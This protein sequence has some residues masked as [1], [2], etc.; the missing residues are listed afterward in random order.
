[1]ESTAGA[2][3]GAAGAVSPARS[4]GVADAGSNG[5]DSRTPARNK[6]GRR[7]RARPTTAPR[8]SRGPSAN[9]LMIGPSH[10]HPSD[11]TIAEIRPL[12]RVSARRFKSV[13]LGQSLSCQ[14]TGRSRAPARSAPEGIGSTPCGWNLRKTKWR[15]RVAGG[16]K[17]RLNRGVDAA[18]QARRQAIEFVREKPSVPRPLPQ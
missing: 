12:S 1:A 4:P 17:A 13:A 6:Y 2:A 14:P 8:P 5:P 16:C 11:E 7:A 3:A 10:P 18:L 9:S 15:A